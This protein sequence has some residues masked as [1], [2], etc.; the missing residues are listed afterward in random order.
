MTDI[1]QGALSSNLDFTAAVWSDS[2]SRTTLSDSARC[3]ANLGYFKT[4][5][6]GQQFDC[7]FHAGD[8]SD[9]VSGLA[10]IDDIV[11]S[12]GKPC[13][14]ARGNHDY[15][16]TNAQLGIPDP[17]YYMQD[18]GTKWRLIV[19][20]STEGGTQINPNQ[21]KLGATQQTFLGDELANLA[22]DNKFGI[23]MLH[24]PIGG[25][26]PLKYEMRQEADDPAVQ[27]NMGIIRDMMLDQYTIGEALNVVP[28]VKLVIA[29]HWHLRDWAEDRG[30]IHHDPGAISGNFWQ[31]NLMLFGEVPSYSKLA[32]FKDGT[33]QKTNLYYPYIN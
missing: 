20:D 13:Y 23:V 11:T 10:A 25:Y 4:H 31:S 28:N 14:K 32:F 8:I 22:T 27:A 2:H 5:L 15:W 16:A 3:I 17:G 6:L 24:V 33:V 12:T 19:L 30:L 26:A 1:R 9:E 18:L 21:Y 7:S 29:G